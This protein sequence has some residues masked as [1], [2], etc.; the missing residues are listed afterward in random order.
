M[1]ILIQASSSQ[2]D[3]VSCDLA[4]VEF[5]PDK[6]RD[7][8]IIAR[9]ASSQ[10]EA[11]HELSFWDS[12]A[13]FYEGYIEVEDVLTPD[14]FEKFSRDQY[15]IVPDDFTLSEEKRDGA[16]F[17]NPMR[18]EA[19]TLCITDDSFYWQSIVKH[20]DVRVETFQIKLT[21]VR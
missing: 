1:K 13:R 17:E 16:D 8:A 9:Q 6:V 3:A 21:V 2:G 10:D 20:C 11:F 4:L 5:D 18:T 7:R 14:L 19:D 12:S 15:V